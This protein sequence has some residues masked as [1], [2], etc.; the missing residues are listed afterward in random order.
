MF[1]NYFRTT[2]RHLLRNKVNFCFK[3]GGLTLALFS[4]L[5]ITLYV[6]YQRSFDTFHES[7]ENVYRVN[8]IREE[9]D[10][11]VNYSSVPPAIGPAL[12]ANFPEV[13]AYARL[14]FT[15][16]L[17]LQYKEK[18]FRMTGIVEADS[19]VF[20]VLSFTFLQGDRNALHQPG[21][22]VLTKSTARQIFGDEDPINKTITS[23]DHS[24]RILTV[25]GV[26]EDYPGNSHLVINAI[27]SVGALMDAE[28]NSWEITWDG[29]VNL[30]V[31]LA[32]G[33]DSHHLSASAV[34]FI[35]ENLVK[36]KEGGESN[37]SIYLQPLANIYLDSPLKMEFHK[38]GNAQ[39]IYVFSIL[40]IFL[41]AIACIN[42]VNL[43][44]ADFDTRTREIGVRKVLGARRRQVGF[45]VAIEAFGI[46]IVSLV[47]AVGL[48]Y[49]LFPIVAD[50][51]DP[52]LTFDMILNSNVIFICALT[53]IAIMILST[54]YP[55]YILATQ[56]PVQDLKANTTYAS[57]MNVGKTLLIVQ[58]VISII[59]ICA[60]VIID[61]Q[62]G[63]VR[64]TDLGYNRTNIVSLVMPD[65]YPPKN[66]SVLKEQMAQLAGVEAVSYS[67]YLMPISTYFKGW[68]QVE[69][70]GNMESMLLNEMFVDYNYLE[71]MGIRLIA[72]RN[73]NVDNTLDVRQSFIINETAAKHFGWS[74]PLGKRIK[75][76]YPGEAE[77][78]S[79]GSV[80]GI[81]KDFH[82]LSLHNKIE[83]VILR[84][85]YDSWPGN[86]LNVRINGSLAEVLPAI[87]A[88]YEKVMSG[89]LADVR[90]VE[91]LHERQYQ[92]E[93]RVFSSLQV[94]TVV[95]MLV[96]AFG[97]FSLSVYMSMRRMKEFGIRKVL[98]ASV[99]QIAFLH[100]SY[101]LKIIALANI[102]ALPVA[103]LL[104][105]HWLS[106]FA[107]RTSLDGLIFFLALLISCI[108]IIISAGY[109]AVK[110]GS[111]NPV[112]VIKKQ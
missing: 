60:T 44:I 106:G 61:K 47:L 89:F 11:A 81:V 13:E 67:Y 8:S 99:K 91:D 57:S 6:S 17:M 85:P 39:Y 21:S 77:E 29:S 43:S 38:K 16:R 108:L 2:I 45:Q 54:A 107:Y 41:L 90:I 75:V 9:D 51:L 52:N 49:I 53:V 76:G 74:D 109:S 30:Y 82:T 69:K 97:I 95:V 68:Y 42:Y 19:T 59:C 66:V 24:D 31:R 10:K 37:F 58:C 65:E 62:I 36:S 56:N 1:R 103:Y 71:T 20:D 32:P 105:D 40:G 80:I 3:A 87:V 28:W 93:A 104:M 111:M 50:M 64:E 34:P 73:F 35:R 63:F 14:G 18:L 72:G 23:P 96:S 101:F 84:L 48:L 5:I 100:I 22:V 46:I 25:T 7:H 110:A 4:L 12:R 83:P 78:F 27:H 15:T 112:D 98:G 70:K 94:A 92:N 33:A 88:T 79:D 86:S 26:I 55:S 102:V